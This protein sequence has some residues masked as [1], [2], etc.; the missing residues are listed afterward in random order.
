MSNVRVSIT[1]AL[2][3]DPSSIA[4]ISTD[5]GSSVIPSTPS[6]ISASSSPSVP[7]P[8]PA[9]EL[10]PSGLVPSGPVFGVAVVVAVIGGGRVTGPLGPSGR[11]GRNPDMASI[12]FN[13]ESGPPSR[14]PEPLGP[15]GPKGPPIPLVP[16]LVPPVP[17]E[18]PPG[19]PPLEGS[20]GPV[21]P[22]PP[23]PGRLG[24]NLSPSITG[25]RVGFTS[26]GLSVGGTISSSSGLIILASLLSVPDP[27]PELDPD[28]E[29]E[30]D[31]DPEPDP[32][33]DP[34]PDPDPEPEPEPD[35]DPD[36]DPLPPF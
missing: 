16:P 12:G 27:G 33:P 23:N 34:V 20:P 14:P 22:P 3:P 7:V 25:G 10:V 35:P 11:P 15:P 24:S 26:D 6:I 13:D 5:S 28:P 29:P 17:P 36:P 2:M 19:N 18:G 30:P 1:V 9:P 21:E 32:V 8:V 31:P 4:M